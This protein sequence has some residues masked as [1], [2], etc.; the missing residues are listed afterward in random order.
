MFRVFISAPGDLV[1]DRE[2]CRAAISRVNETVAMPAKVLLVSVGLRE[3]DQVVGY[4]GAVA[5]NI[6]AAS[7]FVQ[8]F[9]DDWGPKNLFRKMF[10]LALECRD[11]AG[12]PMRDA[13]V[14]LKDAPQET[15]PEILAFRREL[16]QRADVRIVRYSR[17]ED[18][19]PLLEDIFA[20]WARSVM[21]EL[22]QAAA[23]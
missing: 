8:I 5:D 23:G 11:D 21:A 14:C 19:G 9:E 22:A 6:R 16:E 10:L 12:L 4:R 17:P 18:L 3:D 2:T 7:W 15:D 1:P 13:I 20:G